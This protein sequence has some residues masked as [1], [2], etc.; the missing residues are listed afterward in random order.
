MDIFNQETAFE[1]L[2][3]YLIEQWE[4]CEADGEAPTDDVND[5]VADRLDDTAEELWNERQEDVPS[6]ND[7]A[8]SCGVWLG[9]IDE[10]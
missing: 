10:V 5:Y 3:S 1:N 6:V 2:R 7:L 8:Y 9:H 4:L